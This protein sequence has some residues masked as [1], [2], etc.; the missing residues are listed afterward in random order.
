MKR[1][2]SKVVFSDRG[3]TL[4]ELLVAMAI[5]GVVMGAI[6]FT[7]KSQQDSFAVQENVVQM[8]Q[9][10]R[11]AMHFMSRDIQMA[12][13]YT[14]FDINSYNMDWD[15]T[16]AGNE[17]IQP[18]IYARDNDADGGGN[19]VRDGTDLILIVKA[20]DDRGTLAAGEA[21][22]AGTNQMTL[23]DLDLDNDGDVDLNTSGKKYGVLIKSD[24]SKAEFFTVTGAGTPV[25]VNDN[26]SVTYDEGDTIARVDIII[27][28]INEDADPALEMRNLGSDNG[29]QTVAEDITDLQIQ[30]RL[31]NGNWVDDPTGSLTDIREVQ[32]VL[33]SNVDIPQLAGPKQRSLTSTV[34]VRN[35][36]ISL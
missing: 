28:K 5:A 2:K 11:G 17:T 22:V 33:S 31:S 10:L 9:N 14:S 15:P 19:D 20:S 18:I 25:T 1:I 29:F 36:G 23:T 4:I 24:L 7:F 30:Y 12:G 26:F 3:F 8:H 35:L 6:I 27:Y 32:V 13:F 21:V 34:K 16:T